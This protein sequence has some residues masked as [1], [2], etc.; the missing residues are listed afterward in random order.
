MKPLPSG[1]L[2]REDQKIWRQVERRMW[3]KYVGWSWVRAVYQ[4]GDVRDA[5]LMFA[6]CDVK[7]RMRYRPGQIAICLVE[8]WMSIEKQGVTITA[9]LNITNCA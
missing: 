9:A 4:G 2:T 5:E 8:G 3:H 6:M 1:P 7:A